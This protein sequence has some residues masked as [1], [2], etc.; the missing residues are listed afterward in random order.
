M[1]SQSQA[2]EHQGDKQMTNDQKAN[3]NE[4]PPSADEL[5]MAVLK[6]KMEE[7]ERRE[8]AQAAE[9]QRLEKFTDEF[10]GSHVNDTE[11]A[12]IRRLVANAVKDGE[13]EA[14]VYTFPSDLCINNSE[15]HWP[16]TL[17]GKAKELYDRFQANAK[18]KGFKLKAMIVNFPGGIPGDVGFFINWAPER[19]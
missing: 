14:L 8:K 5:R 19:K 18:L 4:P 7:I 16:E 11:L 6:G 1:T 10:L 12:M 13:F 3:L 15:P 2:S 17:K 9:R